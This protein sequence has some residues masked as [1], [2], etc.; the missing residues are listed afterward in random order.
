MLVL[1]RKPN[2]SI[3]IGDDVE[4]SVVEVK[5]D[6]VKLGIT[7]PKS[8]KVHRKEIFLAIQKENIDASRP[9]IDRIGEIGGIF[10]KKK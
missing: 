3:M 2:E 8:I 5:G 6:Q 1:T 9:V 10:K 4:V 7:A